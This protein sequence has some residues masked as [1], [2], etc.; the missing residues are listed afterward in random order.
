MPFTAARDRTLLRLQQILHPS[1]PLCKED[2]IWVLEYIKKKVA[3]EE[4]QLTE[5]PQ[6]Q[7]LKSYCYFTEIAMM[8][9]H[10][11][12]PPHDSDRLKRLIREAVEAI[13]PSS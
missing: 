12:Q 4:S 6:P 2:M 1:H 10:Q 7:L 9:I 3:D 5:L 13:T 8:L 11:R